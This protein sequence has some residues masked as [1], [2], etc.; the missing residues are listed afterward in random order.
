[1]KKYLGSKVHL[2]ALASAALFGFALGIDNLSLGAVC[3]LV[4]IVTDFLSFKAGE[5]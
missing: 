3:F 1:M 4:S 5:S 2:L